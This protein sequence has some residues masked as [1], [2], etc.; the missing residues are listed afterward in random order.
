MILTGT[1]RLGKDCE[2][3]ATNTGET[4]ANFNVAF[5]Y[6]RKDDSGKRPTQWVRCAL[7]GKLA[8]ALAPYLL[9]GQQVSIVLRDVHVEEFEG[10]DGWMAS[11][12]G[13]VSDIELVG[14]RP[15][16]SSGGDQQQAPR[17]GAN[18]TQQPAAS[19]RQARQADPAY[20]D[21]DIPF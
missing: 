2:I 18:R 7:W 14:G 12:V 5:N 9:K 11:L 8:D 19:Q 17:Q 1:G 20:I 16:A 15:E 21:D 3:R 10:K 4:V 13:N 6:G